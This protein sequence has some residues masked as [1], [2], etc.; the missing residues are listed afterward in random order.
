MT[1]QQDAEDVDPLSAPVRHAGRPSG[2]DTEGATG[3]FHRIESFDVPELTRRSSSSNGSGG[4]KSGPCKNS[5]VRRLIPSW[6]ARLGSPVRAQEPPD[7]EG[8]EF[9]GDLAA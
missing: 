6:W 2:D 4:R 9:A 1:N 8:T 7:P 3:S 5:E